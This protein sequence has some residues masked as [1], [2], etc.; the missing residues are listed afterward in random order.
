[1]SP[2]AITG[3]HRAGTS[4]VAKAL[5]LAGL[6]LR[7]HDID[8]NGPIRRQRFVDVVGLGRVWNFIARH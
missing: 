5:R 8:G 7:I 3:M 1:M 2:V 4:T 6:H